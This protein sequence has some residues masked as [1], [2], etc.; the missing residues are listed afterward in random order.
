MPSQNYLTRPRPL[1]CGCIWSRPLA[2]SFCLNH[3][4]PLPWIF[5]LLHPNESGIM[6]FT[7]HHPLCLYAPFGS[8]FAYK[9]FYSHIF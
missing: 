8:S 3:L 4:S 1:L 5:L 2:S 6:T 7:E 9:V